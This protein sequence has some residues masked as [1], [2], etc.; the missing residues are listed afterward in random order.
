VSEPRPIRGSP[1]PLFDRL[2]QGSPED[3]GNERRILD[4]RNIRESVLRDL[5]RLLNTRSSMSAPL[6]HLTEG[7][8]LDYGLPDFSSF[9]PASD[10]DRTVLAQG[11]AAR[12]A[13]HESRLRNVRVVL[14]ADKGNAKAVTGV[15]VASLLIGTVYEPVNFYMTMD[16]AARPGS[17]TLA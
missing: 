15:I 3:A 1:L 4:S 16:L 8:V 5:S 14:R 7:T 9:S 12:I 13:A 6:R 2:A 11:I 10:A 17:I